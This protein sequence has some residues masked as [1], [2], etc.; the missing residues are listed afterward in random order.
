[1]RAMER[2]MTKR[3]M[4]HVYLWAAVALL[5]VV[6][7][8][9]AARAQ[10]WTTSTN[11]SNNINSTNSG[12]V[13][14]GTSAPQAKLDVE[15]SSAYGV[16]GVFSALYAKG[17]AD[18]PMAL[19]LDGA[20]T[21]DNVARLRALNNGQTKWQLNFGDDVTYYSWLNS[22]FNQ[23]FSL[24]SGGN[25][26]FGASSPVF[27]ANASK[28][29]LFDAGPG[30]TDGEIGVG[31][32]Q[33]GTGYTVGQYAFVNSNLSG[34]EKRV[35]TIGAATDGAT[36]GGSIEFYTWNAGVVAERARI[37]KSG[38]F[39]IGT[40]NPQNPLTIARSGSAPYTS[41]P[42]S[43]LLQLVDKTDNTPQILFGSAYNGMWL[44][45]TGTDGTAT[46]Q[47]LGV[48]T[49]GAGEAFVINNNGQVG[50]GTTNP[51][52]NIKLDV[53]GAAHVGGSMTVDGNISAK[54]QDVAEWVPSSQKL[55]AGTVVVLDTT[56]TNSVLASTK[57]YDTRVAGVV[58][59]SP[60][61]ILGQD[62]EGKLKVATTGRVRV[63]VDATRA[64]I[65]VGDLLV[66]SDVEGVAMKSVPLV[67]AGREMH[68]PGTIVGKALEPL[69]RGT[70][71][72][73]VLLSLQ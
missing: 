13:G 20:G 40:A 68:A 73:L 16:G 37:D 2:P 43:E 34:A 21:N 49:G 51:G 55:S 44:R 45:Y 9:G 17:T 15:G 3:A 24:T 19:M 61:V 5:A 58:S 23:R 32:N 11:S 72:I 14:V 8:P 46:N 64:P 59:D 33:S 31:S 12:N 27:D 63:K 57:P 70:G 69:D 7:I 25:A 22:T 4:P 10:Q 47:R 38:N 30:V 39:G 29:L 54:Y 48:V 35:A 52:A 18:Y 28:F 66:T 26:V 65:Q 62:G 53:N 56:R 41:R 36:N 67:I 42:A 71:E 6:S 60:G 50:V 1:M